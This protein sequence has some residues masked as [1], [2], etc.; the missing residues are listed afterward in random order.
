METARFQGF[1]VPKTLIIFIIS[2]DYYVTYITN[3]I[4]HAVWNKHISLHPNTIILLEFMAN[5]ILTIYH[6]LKGNL[7]IAQLVKI[8]ETSLTSSLHHFVKFSFNV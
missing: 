3:V 1:L 6:K 5:K 8:L 7:W 2:S 4:L